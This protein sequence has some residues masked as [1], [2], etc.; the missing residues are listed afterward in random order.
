MT[1][2]GW[3]CK[4]D[5][6]GCIGIGIFACHAQHQRH[7]QPH[8]IGGVTS[9]MTSPA[10]RNSSI[11]SR[12]TMLSLTVYSYRS[13]GTN[14]VSSAVLSSKF[15]VISTTSSPVAVVRWRDSAETRCVCAIAML[16]MRE[17]QSSLRAT[18]HRTRFCR[19]PNNM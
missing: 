3:A 9:G 13:L 7:M 19:W 2:S 4:L 10:L 5:P 6:A 16:P 15:S 11:S 1:D 14:C 8:V 12:I 18:D 17:P